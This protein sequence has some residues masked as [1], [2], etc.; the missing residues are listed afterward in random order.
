MKNIKNKI[1]GKSHNMLF[2]GLFPLKSSIRTEIIAGLILAAIG[3]PEV[4]SYAKI[5][6]YQLSRDF[7]LF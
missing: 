7:T 3:I 4:M 6:E 5:A 2:S 1:V